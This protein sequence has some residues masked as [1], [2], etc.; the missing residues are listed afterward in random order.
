[1]V[2]GDNEECNE[3]KEERYCISP[4]SSSIHPLRSLLRSIMA[5]TNFPLVVPVPGQRQTPSQPAIQARF[6]PG[7]GGGFTLVSTSSGK[8]WHVINEERPCHYGRILHAV[9]VVIGTSPT[10][11][12]LVIQD[13][14]YFAIKV[15]A[16]QQA[17]GFCSN[18]RV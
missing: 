15:C 4:P 9:R 18:I 10:T 12:A 7:N 3:I 14:G 13:R 11:G 8:H 2:C 1:M 17:K 6:R 5:T 16:H